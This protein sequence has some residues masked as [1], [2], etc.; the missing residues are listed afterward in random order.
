MRLDIVVYL[1]Y[2]LHEVIVLYMVNDLVNANEIVNSK[3]MMVDFL[4]HYYDF[5]LKY[6]H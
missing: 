2:S 1:H 3:E 6:F 4:K 5:F